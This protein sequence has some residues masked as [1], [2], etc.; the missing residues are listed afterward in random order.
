MKYYHVESEHTPLIVLSKTEANAAVIAAQFWD[1]KG[2]AIG[3]FSTKAIPP[4]RARKLT[5]DAIDLDQPDEGVFFGD[6]DNGWQFVSVDTE[7]FPF[8]A[9]STE[10]L[11]QESGTVIRLAWIQPANK[12]MVIFARDDEVATLIMAKLFAN[13]DHMPAEWTGDEWDRYLAGGLEDHLKTALESRAEGLGLYDRHGGWRIVSALSEG[14]R[15]LDG[16]SD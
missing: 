7:G 1:H 14:T 13:L 12:Q 9:F 4:V 3:D 11:P 2:L 16:P 8:F 10:H 6:A 5:D 15:L